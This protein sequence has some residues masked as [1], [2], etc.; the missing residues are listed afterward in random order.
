MKT[1]FIKF[2]FGGLLIIIWLWLVDVEELVSLF[3]GVDLVWTIPL[4]INF[5]VITVLSVLKLKILVELK[6]PASFWYLLKLN[7]IGATASL[8]TPAQ[9]GGFLRAYLLKRKYNSSF[10]GAFGF[11]LVDFLYTVG[12]IFLLAIFGF[13]F[14]AL[15]G[16]SLVVQR[17]FLLLGV[18]LL[19][20]GL[21]GIA[22]PEWV[23]RISFF[24][25]RFI[26]SNRVQKR[27]QQVLDEFWYA[28]FLL[29]RQPARL[30]VAFLISVLVMG[31]SGISAYFIFRSFGVVVQAIP[32]IFACAIGGL[33]NIIPAAPAKV[34]Q[35]ELVGLVVFSAFLG[36]ERSL[37]GGVVL[38]AHVFEITTLLVMTGLV[39]ILFGSNKEFE[40]L[41]SIANLPSKIRGR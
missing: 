8:V 12:A 15:R 17:G 39:F 20:G 40:E 7:L 13:L 36:V 19:V 10:S 18:G 29:S 37:A 21:L 24:V 34:G 27:L 9:G 11:I 23:K 26:P 28:F 35:Y 16:D 4:V 41:R 30:I 33:V 3:T 14:F 1:G 6:F 5:F 31:L 22:K 38:L 25:A 2:L 32:V